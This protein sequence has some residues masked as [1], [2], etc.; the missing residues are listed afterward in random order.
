M[1]IRKDNL[2]IDTFSEK[3]RE[4]TYT[5]NLDK[6]KKDYNEKMAFLD[7]LDSILSLSVRVQT[8]TS[9]EQTIV[10]AKRGIKNKKDRDNKSKN[11]APISIFKPQVPTT[12]IAQ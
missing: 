6:T 7:Q 1:N 2:T 4:L 5:F 9:L 11:Q 8:A 12:C 3:I 10:L